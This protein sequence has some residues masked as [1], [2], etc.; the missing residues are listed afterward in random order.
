[1]TDAKLPDGPKVTPHDARH[2]FVSYAAELGLSSDDV[3]GIVG[4]TSAKV[5]EAIYHHAF[6]REER[7]ARQREAMARMAEATS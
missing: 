7:E 2:A 4:H 3:A 5:T 1:M 6:N